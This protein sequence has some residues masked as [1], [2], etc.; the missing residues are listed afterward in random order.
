MT[1]STSKHSFV[2]C[3]SKKLAYNEEQYAINLQLLE[4]S[5]THI[6]GLY[7]YRL[8]TDELTSSDVEHLSSDYRRRS[9]QHSQNVQSLQ[10]WVH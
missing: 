10:G 7:E 3:F 6:K 5:I 1:Y 4:K 2:Y 9:L 8:I